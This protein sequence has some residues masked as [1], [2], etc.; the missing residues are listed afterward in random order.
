MSH[1]KRK[2][3]H[4][5]QSCIKKADKCPTFHLSFQNIP[6]IPQDF[7]IFLLI[8]HKSV[9]LYSVRD[10]FGESAAKKIKNIPLSNNTISRR[11]HDIAED[12]N[13]QIVEKL[14]GLFAI[15]LDEAIDSNNDAQ[16]ICYVRYM[17]EA[18]VSTD[19]KW[20]N[21]VGVST[22]GA[23]SMSGQYGGLQALIKTEAPNAKW[24]HCW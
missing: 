13:E 2:T 21:C 8:S 12:I 10:W 3:T 15:Q 11:I 17:E 14:S 24:T 6:T 9:P 7:A 4:R 23:R 20:E 19:I 22:D 16:L 5:E 1:T 18:N